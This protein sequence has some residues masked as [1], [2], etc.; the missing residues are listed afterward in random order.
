MSFSKTEKV[1]KRRAG[2]RGK[3][4]FDD[5]SEG[6]I[7][8]KDACELFERKLGECPA[9][10]IVDRTWTEAEARDAAEANSVKVVVREWCPR[11]HLFVFGEEEKDSGH[12]T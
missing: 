10:V 4:W 1:L 3:I 2:Q 8:V 9:I 7:K 5:T 11:H 6:T 12:E